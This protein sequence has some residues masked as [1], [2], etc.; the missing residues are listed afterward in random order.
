MIVFATLSYKIYQ[1][2]SRLKQRDLALQFLEKFWHTLEILEKEPQNKGLYQKVVFSRTSYTTWLDK[3]IIE[4]SLMNLALEI[5]K[6]EKSQN[7]ITDILQEIM[8]LKKQSF[9]IF[10]DLK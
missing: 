8:K 7:N 1:Q 5:G 10:C 3:N 6:S 9:Q 4:L 2:T